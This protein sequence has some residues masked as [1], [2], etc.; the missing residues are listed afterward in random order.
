MKEQ[1]EE[2]R[3]LRE[4][5]DQHEFEL[6][7]S[8]WEHMADILDGKQPV[9]KPQP[10]Q[11]R[12]RRKG[13]LWLLLALP[14]LLAVG[15]G[16]QQLGLFP[17]GGQPS[18]LNA[19]PIPM[20]YAQQ[21]TSTE[22]SA[23]R[24]EVEPSA[25]ALTT[26]RKG[27]ELSKT[28]MRREPTASAATAAAKMNP[29]IVVP[30]V[31]KEPTTPSNP[32]PTPAI[33][34]VTPTID[35]EE[36]TAKLAAIPAASQTI[37]PPTAKGLPDGIEPLADLSAIATLSPDL[38]AAPEAE[39]EVAQAKPVLPRR[40]SFGLK[41]GLDVQTRQTTALAG[42]FA[43]YRLSDKWALQLEPQYK[44]RS[45]ENGQGLNLEKNETDTLFFPTAVRFDQRGSKITRLHF[46]EVPLT[47]LYRVHPRVQLLG[48]GQ[49]VYVQN[50]SRSA[51]IQ[52]A[53][54]A[55]NEFAD[56]T[57]AEAA[58]QSSPA[59]LRWDVG[60]ILG[61]DYQI[62]PALSADLRY[63]QGLYDLTSDAFFLQEDNYLNSSLQ[64][65]IKWKW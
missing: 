2:Y 54:Q 47:A 49:L 20:Q 55:A 42:L 59:I 62:T 8:S 39:L 31:Q 15:V 1:N 3:R 27:A 40:F 48:G 43:R 11:E 19:L 36:D 10:P 41:A 35:R 22:D 18:E 26:Q 5:L 44:F 14:L 60:L 23:N 53:N 38:L 56:L 16:A 12:N 51:R 50:E 58:A 17:A 61:V 25:D 30:P 6:P 9:P 65:S 63:V 4:Q 57:Y 33:A 52:S 7:A 37:T 21:E 13:F 29:P 34:A 46:I 28:T 64:L 45:D 24:Q 32:Q